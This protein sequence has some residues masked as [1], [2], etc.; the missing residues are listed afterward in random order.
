MKIPIAYVALLGLPLPRSYLAAVGQGPKYQETK[1]GGQIL[2]A[3]VD[4]IKD[5]GL[6]GVPKRKTKSSGDVIKGLPGS[7][8]DGAKS[9]SKSEMTRLNKNGGN[10]GGNTK[11]EHNSW[12]KG[13]LCRRDGA[14]LYR[15]RKMQLRPGTRA[16]SAVVAGILGSVARPLLQALI[17]WDHPIGHAVKWFDDNIAE[18]Q[19]AIGGKPVP[20]ISGNE[21]HLG[22]LC[23]LRGEQEHENAV[24]KACK[25]QNQK[26][27]KEEQSRGTPEEQ[28]LTGVNQLL[29]GCSA[30]ETD[31]PEDQGR[32]AD[33]ENGCSEFENAVYRLE[34]CNCH[35][36]LPQPDSR[37]YGLCRDLIISES[38][39]LCLAVM[40][41]S[42]PNEDYQKHLVKKNCPPEV[43]DRIKDSPDLDEELRKALVE[44]NCP[45]PPPPKPTPGPP[46]PPGPSRQ[47]FSSGISV[48]CGGGQSPDELETGVLAC[49]ICGDSWD[50][51]EGRCTNKQGVRIWPPSNN[52]QRPQC[53]DWD[54]WPEGVSC[55]GGQ[56]QAELNKGYAVCSACEFKWEMEVGGCRGNRDK[57]IWPRSAE[58]P[59][60]AEHS[61]EG[62]SSALLPHDEA[63]K[64]TR[65]AGA[66]KKLLLATSDASKCYD[67][68]L[69]RGDNAIARGDGLEQCHEKYST[70]RLRLRDAR[71][72]REQHGFPSSHIWEQGLP[73]VDDDRRTHQGF[74]TKELQDI[75]EKLKKVADETANHHGQI[76]KL[77]QQQQ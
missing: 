9:K 52:T 8:N 18:L 61:H 1:P 51:E 76:K 37:C 29:D 7:V 13:G 75:V 34:N 43:C 69:K 30:L 65:Y 21:L 17:E 72:L 36:G 48:P 60:E 63:D 33:L 41:E 12:T 25:R 54:E 31:Y 5:W 3:A 14:C 56:T 62:E 74:E 6:A 53:S 68:Y 71:E 58:K 2:Q 66:I 32:R 45:P 35:L 50:E 26:E 47:C 55:G 11:K 64:L 10:L 70:A 39:P 20:E 59:Q 44:L 46:E 16:G 57:Y 24:D 77:R 19:Q 4:G 40:R 73:D 49:Q 23:W 38:Y 42:H 27:E 28:W 15:S 22:I 67:D